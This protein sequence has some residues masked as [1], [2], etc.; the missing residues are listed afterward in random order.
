MVANCAT[1]SH[2]AWL[3]P[4]TFDSPILFHV[5]LNFYD[6]NLKFL[7]EINDYN[8]YKCT[9][10]MLLLCIIFFSRNSTIPIGHF[11]IFQLK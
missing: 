2:K 10:W 1:S 3:R 8:L 9:N 11:D 6:E 5:F 4:I 7:R